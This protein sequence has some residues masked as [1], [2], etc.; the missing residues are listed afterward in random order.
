MKKYK[1]IIPIVFVILFFVVLLSIFFYKRQEEKK[2]KENMF[3][4]DVEVYKETYIKDIVNHKKV[5]DNYK[6]NT[7]KLGKSTLEYFYKNEKGKKKK[8][9]VE[10]N[11]VDSISP[12]VWLNTSYTKIVGSED[13][14]RDVIL[15]GDNYDKN[16]SCKIEGDYDL[17]KVG[18]YPLKYIAIDASKN[19][20]EIDFV[21]HVIEEKD[22][23]EETK[24][25]FS[26]V[27]KEYKEDNNRLGLDISAWQ[28]EVDFKKLKEAGVSFVM[29]RVGY[30]KDIQDIEVLDD[31]FKKNIESAIKEGLD[32][33]VYF[34]SKASTKEEAINQAK[35]VYKNIKDYK[36]TL[37]VVFD[38]EIYTSFNQLNIS[39]T[40]L[41]QIADTFMKKI[42]DYGYTPALYASKN[43]LDKI[44]ANERY[45]T[46]L[47]H[48]TKQTTYDKDYFMWQMCMDGKID[49]IEG[50]VDIDIL[51]EEQL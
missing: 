12:L 44:W 45:A 14:L 38:W 37:P 13:N 47:A 20:T 27:Y 41:N 17:S 48:Y 10:V 25:L 30:Q 34:Y 32:V 7:E 22:E 6:I 1:I 28:R 18:N 35:F 23:V 8:A 15:C 16:P 33:G 19:K 4:V 40:D 43:Y 49:G 46:W 24:T 51:Y 2:L 29:L 26:D 42:K 3:H 50:Y 9:Y 36:I 31:Y 21:L 39:L 11:V 5:I